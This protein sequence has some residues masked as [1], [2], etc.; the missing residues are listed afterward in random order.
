MYIELAILALFTFFYSV[1]A[2]R[3]EKLPVSGPIVFVITGFML[4]PLGLGWFKDDVSQVEFRVL[5]DLTL[6]LILFIDAAN[7]DTSI[8]RRQWRI[9]ARMLGL[10]LPGAIALGF[11]IAAWLFDN[12]TVYEAAILATMLAATD[13]ALGKAV[14]SNPTVPSRLREGLNCESGLNDG[15]CVPILLVFIALAHGSV[16]DETT[17]ALT[18]VA[19]ELGI[20][21]VVGLV[22]AGSGAW[23]LD[24]SYKRD[25]ISDV[26][27]QVSVPALAIAS[28][29]FAQSL[30][31]SGYIAAFVGGMLFGF[32][33]RA[34]THKLVMPGEAI[35]EGMSMLTW[36]IF[37]VA[38]IGQS[39]AAFTWQIIVY[40][41]LSLTLV[42]MLPIFLSLLGT[43]ETNSSKLFLGWFGPRGLASI[44][45][46]IIVL[47]ENL[48]GGDFL[49][50]VVTCTV[51]LSLILH[52]VSANPLAGLI[53]RS[54]S[55]EPTEGRT[56]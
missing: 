23:L 47:D 32:I 52:G 1:V 17:L 10:G 56:Q 27:V 18:L 35:S 41:I 28:F 48:P 19:K 7:A 3:I 43:S 31:G 37:G 54:E 8:L 13:A 9:P 29:A 40:S 49:A 14:V 12:L 25:W 50:M 55:T 34:A 20:G 15:L 51:G 33:A 22:V 4:G 5:V 38:V 30:H 16:A 26:W 24:F 36:L 11:I 42:R 44:V 53:A 6:A 21:L 46:A 45:F 2:G 39:F